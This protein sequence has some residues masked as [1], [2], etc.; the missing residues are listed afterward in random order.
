MSDPVLQQRREVEAEPAHVAMRAKE[1]VQMRRVI[2]QQAQPRQ[3]CAAQLS[4]PRVAEAAHA[5]VAREQMR[6]RHDPVQ[7]AHGFVGEQEGG[8]GSE[9]VGTQVGVSKLQVDDVQHRCF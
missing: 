6:G 4:A 7:V 1:H 2:V 5:S 8:H 9:D 3:R